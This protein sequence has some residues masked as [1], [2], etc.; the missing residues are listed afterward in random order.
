VELAEKVAALEL[1]VQAVHQEQM[2]LTAL[3]EQVELRELRERME[4]VAVQ[5][6]LALAVHQEAQVHQAQLVRLEQQELRVQQVQQENQQYSLE[7]VVLQ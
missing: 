6:L 3:V 4:R 7:Q 2:V 1:M 5:V